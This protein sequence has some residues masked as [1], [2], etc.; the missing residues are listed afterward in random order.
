MVLQASAKLLV[1]P[2]TLIVCYQSLV[3]NEFREG[4]NP[5]PE[6]FWASLSAITAAWMI[7]GA[8]I[9]FPSTS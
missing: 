4:V 2:V 5:L 7:F 3:A 8:N 9:L 6:A 1:A